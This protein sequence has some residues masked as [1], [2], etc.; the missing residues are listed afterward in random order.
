MNYIIQCPQAI[1]IG[2]GHPNLRLFAKG[3]DPESQLFL[4]SA[5]GEDLMFRWKAMSYW[6]VTPVYS[7]YTAYLHVN[8]NTVPEILGVGENDS[9]AEDHY[10]DAVS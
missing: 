3:A 6:D 1:P 4:A 2:Y 8:H 9:N 10:A 5:M 7:N